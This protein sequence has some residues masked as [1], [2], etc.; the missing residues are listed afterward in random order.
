MTVQRLSEKLYSSRLW[1]GLDGDPFFLNVVLVLQANSGGTIFDA[2][3]LANTF[4]TNTLS[5]SISVTAFPGTRSIA[6]SGSTANYIE[7][8]DSGLWD[9]GTGDFTVE[10]W[11]YI[12]N[13][14]TTKTFVSTYPEW[15]LQQ[16]GNAWVWGHGDPQILNR[17][18]STTNTWVHIAV[19]RSGTNT[20]MFFD[21]VQQGATV[22]NSDDLTSSQPLLIGKLNASIQPATGYMQDLRITKAARYTADFTPPGSLA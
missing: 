11:F 14:S 7:I 4:V 2:G 20:R 3:P 17:S 10:G 19:C 13:A 6:F 22:T 16:R 5:T 12:D 9:F 8:A 18:Y 1:A 21:G 15:E